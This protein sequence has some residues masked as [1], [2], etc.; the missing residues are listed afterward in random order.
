MSTT[1]GNCEI[2]NSTSLEDGG[3]QVNLN[4][5]PSHVLVV[6][7]ALTS[8][9]A[10][11]T[12][13]EGDGYWS[14]TAANFSIS[15]SETYT[16]QDPASGF[17]DG[18]NSTSQSVINS[19]Q[20]LNSG[21]VGLAENTNVG[22]VYTE[23]GMTSTADGVAL[24]DANVEKVMIVDSIVGSSTGNQVLVYAK[25]Y[26]N[27]MMPSEDTTINLDIDGDATW[28]PLTFPSEGTPQGQLTNVDSVFE[29]TS[30]ASSS[31]VETITPT[32]GF[33]I[34]ERVIRSGF[35]NEQTNY[36]IEGVVT[37]NK[38]THVATIQI[39]ANADEYFINAPNFDGY[40]L[41]SP[42]HYGNASKH[43]KLSLDS[44][45]KT[46]DKKTSYVFNLIYQNNNKTT[47]S[48]G[49]KASLSYSGKSII[50]RTERIDSI[51]F[52]GTTVGG[53]ETRKITVH[54]VPDSEFALSVVSV[55]SSVEDVDG[56]GVLEYNFNNRYLDTSILSK[57]NTTLLPSHAEIVANTGVWTNLGGGGR[58]LKGLSHVSLPEL[59]VLYKV[60][61]SSGYY[62]FKQKFPKTNTKTTI[63]N[64]AMSASTIMN[65]DD[66][67]G[68]EVG[69][70][71]LMSAIPTK[72]IIIV[73]T[74]SSATR[75]ITSAAVT[76][77]DNAS[78][79]FRKNKQYKIIFH[80]YINTKHHP[81]NGAMS[82]INQD[83]L[84]DNKEYGVTLNQYIDPTLILRASTAGTALT[85]NGGSAGA[86]DDTAYVG[87]ADRT[88]I[89][90]KHASR[91]TK[92][93]KLTYNL[94][95]VSGGHTFTAARK[96][97]F[98]KVYEWEDGNTPTQKNNAIGALVP[99]SD[100]TNTVAGNNGGT[101]V[102]ITGI[103][104]G[105]TG[106]TTISIT[107]NVTIKKWGNS[108]VTMDLDLD[109]IVTV[110]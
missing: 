48:D 97:A 4:T 15:G 54:G 23:S 41:L 88:S 10:P 53:G 105:S 17:G 47:I 16:T 39:D 78:V 74:V 13:S 68:I 18:A 43:I 62:T 64:G 20:G 21:G 51:S 32:T 73:T 75:V 52:G 84:I 9:P 94:A 33:T 92:S 29:I 85:I 67:T 1:L 3:D 36:V 90:L 72:S 80:K 5:M 95:V 30:L 60:I 77:D 96:P 103:T 55:G 31:G 91:I 99:A 34:T 86:E 27:Y 108:D 109:K 106:A 40:S 26:D 104:I 28:N 46:N 19:N 45:G 22:R 50:T 8:N 100:W 6:V 59:P 70:R 71:V 83:I 65:L 49:L 110:A 87:K 58:T 14:V 2:T 98:S 7:G 25:L 82:A 89:E 101:E 76:A 57:E 81:L 63:L 44:I 66:S 12:D 69:D 107:A 42:T 102:L 24:W 61:D 11:S 38:A 37:A 79:S 93:F 35:S 56:D